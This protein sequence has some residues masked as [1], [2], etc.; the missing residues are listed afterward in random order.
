MYT[1]FNLKGIIIGNNAIS[2]KGWKSLFEEQKTEIRSALD[3]Y[4][5]KDGVIDGHLIQEDWFPEVKADIF[6]SHSHNDEQLA[7]NLACWLYDTFELVAFV[8]SCVWG[9]ANE[10]LKKIDDK[11]CWKATKDVYDYG[12][13]NCSTSHV[14]MMLMTALNKMIDKTEC[15]FFLDTENSVLFKDIGNK[16]LSPWIYGEIEITRTIQKRRPK[17]PILRSFSYDQIL[18]KAQDANEPL[19]VQYPLNIGH[20]KVINNDTLNQWKATNTTGMEALDKLYKIT[21]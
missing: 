2:K 18:E 9:Y 7:I 11:Y 8:D 12:K 15:V 4:I 16:T 19:K 1:G 14:H 5:T 3:K 21:L 10:L 6:I 13:R 17:R 20:F